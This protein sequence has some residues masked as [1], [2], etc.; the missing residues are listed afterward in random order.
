MVRDGMTRGIVG[1][2]A[3]VGAL[4]ALGGTAD[5]FGPFAPANPYAAAGAA[6]TM[7]ADVE[8]SGASPSP[9]PGAGAA[10]RVNTMAAACPTILQGS[11][12][13]PVALCTSILGRNPVVYLLNPATG[14]PL[15]SLSL[16]AGN[17][18]GGVYAYLDPQ[19][20]IVLFNAGGDLL[21]IGHSELDG[22]WHLSVD[23]SSSVAAAIDARCASI[24]GGIVGL[25]PDWSGRVWFATADGVAGFVDPRTGEVQTV[26]LGAGE[27]VANSISTSPTGTAVA[28]DHALYLLSVSAGRPRIVWRY[29]YDRGPARKPGQLS[30]GTGS[31]PVFF[32]GTTGYRYLAFTDNAVP[33]EHL[34]VLDTQPPAATRKRPKRKKRRRVTAVMAP[35]VA[36]TVAVLTPGPSGTEN[37]PVAS[38]SSVFLASTYGYPSYPAGA[39]TSVPASAPF[40]GGMTRVDLAAN[41]KGCHVV[42]QNAVRSAAVPRLEVPDGLLY[43]VQRVDPLAA[44]G[45]SALDSYSLVAID[46]ATGAVRFSVRLG[47]GAL[48]DTL[49]LSPTIVPGAVMYQ[50]T[51]SGI[52]RIAAP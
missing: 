36:C 9:G 46:A 52:D 3:T 23:S 31:T 25:A 14:A 51:I 43:T 45:T 17:L 37:A 10:V 38:G 42:W 6:A 49:Q 29:A 21:R 33:A 2:L 15:A 41:G 50:G 26:A 28:T 44:T 7:H 35:R 13:M 22:R 18:F 24:C 40:A 12:G 27:Q 48:A 1:A 5:A 20:R 30:H 47:S 19:N 4:L 8:S 16:P 32:G 11:D 34:I 39:G